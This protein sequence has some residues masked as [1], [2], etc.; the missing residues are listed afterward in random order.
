M[1]CT[2]PTTN[3]T[4]HDT[5]YVKSLAVIYTIYITLQ[6]IG[7]FYSLQVKIYICKKLNNFFLNII[8]FLPWLF[9]FSGEKLWKF[10]IDLNENTLQIIPMYRIIQFTFHHILH[11]IVMTIINYYRNK[12]KYPVLHSVN[13]LMKVPTYLKKIYLIHEIK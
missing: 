12:T 3:S 7:H 2:L 1:S 4:Q 10:P 5:L 13:K 6:Y 11:K 9:T 8:E